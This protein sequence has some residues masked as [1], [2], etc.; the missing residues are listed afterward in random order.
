MRSEYDIVVLGSGI[1]GTSAALLCSRL[2]ARVLVVEKHAHP[3]FAIGEATVPCTQ[4]GFHNLATKYGVPELYDVNNFIG[5]KKHGLAGWA[6]TNFHFALHSPGEPLKPEHELM[7]ETFP[8][9]KGPDVHIFREDVDA[10]L[11]DRLDDYGVDYSDH[12]E[13]VDFVPDDAGVDC[14][15]VAHETK[16][17][18]RAAF[19]IDCCGYGS[20]LVARYEL[21]D[22]EPPFH[23]HT[24]SIYGHFHDVPLFDDVQEA[25]PAF[26]YRRDAGTVHHCFEGGWIWVIPFDNGITSVGFC[27]DPELWPAAASPEADVASVLER[28]PTIRRHLEGMTLVSDWVQAERLQYSASTIIGPRFVLAPQTG[29]FIDPLYSG[30]LNLNQAFLNRLIPIIKRCLADGDFSESRFKPI[31][32]ALIAECLHLDRIISGSQRGFRHFDMLKQFWRTWAHASLLE[33]LARSAFDHGAIEDVNLLFGAGIE[34]FATCVEEMHDIVSTST[35]PGPVVARKLF[36]RLAGLPAIHSN[37]REGLGSDKA[38]VTQFP[39]VT[40]EYFK[41]WKSQPEVKRMGRVDPRMLLHG[42]I[43]LDLRRRGDY[44]KHALTGFRSTPEHQAVDTIYWA[45]NRSG[46]L[47]RLL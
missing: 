46:F 14:V 33:G 19:V 15:L 21:R 45:Q 11:V 26:R 42:R 17:T 44:L 35:E 30:G 39:F 6:K 1:I 4:I 41:W 12:T 5:L 36:D 38:Y 3:R 18:V 25:N 20:P 13:L 8:L 29:G 31:E 10:F 9:P 27:L 34:T 32:S 16:Q 24:R 22:A 40:H 37:D 2:G 43:W 23:T 28:Y 7:F 47:E